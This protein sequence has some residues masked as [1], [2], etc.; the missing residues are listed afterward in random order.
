MFALDIYPPGLQVQEG[1]KQA[2]Y[3]YHSALCK[4]ISFHMDG[5]STDRQTDATLPCSEE[6]KGKETQVFN[7]QSSLSF[8]FDLYKLNHLFS[9]VMGPCL[10][11][12][13]SGIQTT[14]SLCTQTPEGVSKKW[15]S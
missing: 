14:S 9:V 12:P 8:M 11:I 5:E 3:L 10:Q 7:M 4:H 1:R 2:F 13:E 6:W 15:E